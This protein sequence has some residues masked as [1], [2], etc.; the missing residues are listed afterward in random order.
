MANLNLAML[1]L[2]PSVSSFAPS[3]GGSKIVPHHKHT[4]RPIN[5]V[6]KATLS[7]APA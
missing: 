5:P 6:Y 7:A 1:L 4:F 2:Q 3:L